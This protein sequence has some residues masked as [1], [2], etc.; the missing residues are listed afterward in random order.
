MPDTTSNDV[1]IQAAIQAANHARNGVLFEPFRIMVAPPSCFANVWSNQNGFDIT[2]YAYKGGLPPGVLPLGD[3]AAASSAVVFEMPMMR[4]QAGPVPM[5]GVMVLGLGTTDPDALAHPR[6]FTWVLNDAGSHNP[7][8]ISYWRIEP[9]DGYAALGVCFS[10]AKPNPANYWCVKTE[11]LQTVGTAETWT[12]S[13]THWNNDG[14]VEHPAFVEATPA[15]DGKILLLPQTFLSHQDLANEPAWALCVQQ[16]FLDV[17]PIALPDPAMTPDV[18]SGSATA[19]GLSKVA[20]L[21]F[22][23]VPDTGFPSPWQTSPFYYVAAEPYWSCLWSE[24]MP[25]GGSETLTVTVGADQSHSTTFEHSTSLTISADVGC[26]MDPVT[27]Q[28]SASF[29]ETFS[30]A[31]TTTTSS[32]SSYSEQ[33]FFNVPAAPRAWLHQRRVKLTVFRGNLSELSSIDYAC[34]DHLMLPLTPVQ[35]DADQPTAVPA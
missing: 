7:S 21:P 22:A 30:L 6:D 25:A 12:D 16:A 18:A 26:W 8:D 17:A 27:A 4:S 31:T 2:F 32:S 34:N 15:P 19:A 33:R 23:A 10:Y 29:T 9:P 20:I 5:P 28:A 3:Y 1:R 14:N 35:A 24:S 13:G 11:Y